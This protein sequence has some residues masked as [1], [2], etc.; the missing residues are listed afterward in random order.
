M[1][2]ALLVGRELTPAEL[3]RSWEWA[4]VSGAMVLRIPKLGRSLAAL[5]AARALPRALKGS[6]DLG[7]RRWSV[8]SWAA[9]ETVEGTAEHQYRADMG[10]RALLYGDRRITAGIEVTGS[11]SV[12]KATAVLSW[13]APAGW[14]RDAQMVGASITHGEKMTHG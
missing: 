6:G 14:L 10:V 11:R 2:A 4:M 9:P 1:I 3:T 8:E 13:G 5:E 7:P 12:G